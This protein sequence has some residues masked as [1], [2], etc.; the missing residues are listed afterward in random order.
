LSVQNNLTLIKGV[1]FDWDHTLYD[2]RVAI[3]G[4]TESFVRTIL[5]EVSFQSAVE[6]L[7]SLD[8]E[9]Y[10]SR[11]EFFLEVKRRFGLSQPL[12]VLVELFHQQYASYIDA[13]VAQQMV[14]VLREIGIPFGVVTNGSYR[15]R[16]KIEATGLVEFTACVVM[17]GVLKVEKPDPK[18]FLTAAACLGIKPEAT[19]FVGDHIHNDILGA[20]RVGMQTAWISYGREWPRELL[21]PDIVVS[22][23]HELVSL[24][25]QYRRY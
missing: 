25:S 21:C 6:T 13:S 22:S 7:I 16:E 11:T 12:D 17:S 4:W 19:I 10:C 3:K 18:I 2:R 9:G 15:Q 14:I 8:Q 5:P 20:R 23:L 24:F 1:L